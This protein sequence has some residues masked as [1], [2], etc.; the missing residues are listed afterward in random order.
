MNP[1]CPSPGPARLA[2]MPQGPQARPTHCTSPG[3]PVARGAASSLCGAGRG[4]QAHLMC[5]RCYITLFTAWGPSRQWPGH[6]CFARANSCHCLRGRVPHLACPHCWLCFYPAIFRFLDR[7]PFFNRS[8]CV[9]LVVWLWLT[10]CKFVAGCIQAI[11][12]RMTAAC[13]S[14]YLHVDLFNT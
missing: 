8:L 12:R 14:P 13:T 6:A 3:V 7:S 10:S 5:M 11:A 2:C 1:I 9:L 4:S